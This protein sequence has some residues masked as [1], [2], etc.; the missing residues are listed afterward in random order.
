VPAGA[1]GVPAAVSVTVTVQLAGAFAGV[2]SGQLTVVDVVRA[3]TWMLALPLLDAWTDA[4]A[5]WYVPWMV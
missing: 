4:G 3:V 5:G 2:L 1:L